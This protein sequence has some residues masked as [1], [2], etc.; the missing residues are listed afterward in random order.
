MIHNLFGKCKNIFI[1]SVNKLKGS[2]KRIVLAELSKMKGKGGQSFIAK[3]FRVSRDTIRKG[4]FELKSKQKIVDKFNERGRKPIEEKLTNLLIDIKEIVDFQS[5]TDPSFKTARLYTR[6]SVAE[7]RKQL[8]VQKKYCDE[9]LPTNQTLNN[10]IN[11]LR[12]TLRKVQKTKPLK[13]I[14]ETDAIFDNLK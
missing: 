14:P 3:E 11:A 13:K 9:E 5:Q 4:T 8:I 6:L 7:I 10:K 1:K 2:D 12:Y